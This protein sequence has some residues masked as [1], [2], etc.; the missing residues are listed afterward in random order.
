MTVH[1]VLYV[2]PNGDPKRSASYS[3][4]SAFRFCRR[5]FYLTRV[6]GWRV[7][8]E[9]VA[10]EFGKVVEA[11]V[12]HQIKYHTGG[13][14]EFERLWKKVREQKDFDK[15]EYTKVEQSWENMLRIGREWLIIFSARQDIYPFRQAQFQV[16]L[17][18]KIF[19][20]TTYDELTNVAYL[21]IFSEPESQHPALV[22]VPTTTPYRRL[23]TDVK[24]SSKELDESLVALDPQLIEYAWTYD[25]EDVGFLWF[26][27]KSHGFKHGSRVT[28]LTESGGWPAGTELFVLDPDGKE[29]VWVGSKAEVESYARACTAPDGTSFRGKALDKAAGEFLVQTSA[30]SVPIS[31]VS[32]QLVQFATA[33][34][35]REMI[36]DMGKVV[37]QTTVEMV[38]AHEQDFYPMEP[39]IRYPTDKCS[40]CDMRYICTG[41]TEGRDAVL[42]RIGEEWL[43]SNIEE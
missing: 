30:A 36:E 40:G 38:V 12:V 17:S 35:N 14:A 41:D 18:K 26:V 28:L 25:S 37:G 11:A 10:L 5:Y 33:R 32:K 3:A 31:K 7:K 34:L 22:R 15:R 42:T 1:N 16:P 13:V 9:G 23:I 19:P 4:R 8:H 24:T 20:G 2:L 39:G 27:K 43:D 29:N 21:D 6:R